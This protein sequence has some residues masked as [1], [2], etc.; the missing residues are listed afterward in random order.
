MTTGRWA[1]RV[2]G[3]NRIV[4]LPLNI[5]WL[6][7]SNNAILTKDM[8][9]R[10]LHIRLET[11]CEQPELRTK[12]KHA[13]L[14]G[15][16]A[17]CRRALAIA[18]LS[19]PAGYINAKR[20]VKG[21]PAWGG[22]DDW[23]NL[24]RNSLVWAGLPDPGETRDGLAEQADEETDQLRELLDGWAELGQPVTVNDAID[25]AYAGFAPTLKAVLDSLPGDKE[26]KKKALGNLLRDYRGRPLDRRKLE[27]TDRKRPKWRVVNIG[28]SKATPSNPIPG[29]DMPNPEY[30]TTTRT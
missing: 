10:T 14:L 18:A 22:F 29:V 7:T 3:V 4:D 16:V 20:P 30:S 12:F 25:R 15:H 11:D 21:L 28:D 23:S 27:R 24:V 13:D 1:D 26:K 9:P 17:K 2:L 6:G 5:V 8:T 19:I